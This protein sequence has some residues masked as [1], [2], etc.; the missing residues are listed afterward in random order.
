VVAGVL[1]ISEMLKACCKLHVLVVNDSCPNQSWREVTSHP[2][3]QVLHHSHN[4]GVGAATLTAL[5]AAL[6]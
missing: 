3:V 2:L 6:E 5:Q 4:Q 1:D